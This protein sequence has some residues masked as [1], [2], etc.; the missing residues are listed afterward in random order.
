M[1]G[2][3]LDGCFKIKSV[4]SASPVPAENENA[5]QIGKKIFE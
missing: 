5:Y 4:E 1:D 2:P 3:N